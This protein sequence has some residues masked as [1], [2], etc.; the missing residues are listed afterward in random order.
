MI[1]EF[2][3]T[4]IRCSICKEFKHHEDISLIKKPINIHN[5]KVL[6]V[7]HI[8]YCNGSYSCL[9]GACQ[10]PVRCQITNDGS[11]DVSEIDL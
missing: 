6:G 3:L 5:G 1:N 7:R 10:F 4:Q 9:L 8:K 2:D 11:E